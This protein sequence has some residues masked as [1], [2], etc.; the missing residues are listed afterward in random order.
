MNLIKRQATVTTMLFFL[1]T[2]QVNSAEAASTIKSGALCTK[3][4][5]TITSNGN[6][7]K[8]VKSGKKLVWKSL[9]AVMVKPSIAPSPTPAPMSSSTPAP[10]ASPTPTPKPTPTPTPFKANIPITLPLSVSS[11]SNAITF[12]NIVSRVT[13]IPQVAWQK[14][15]N[16]LTA[17]THVSVVTEIFVGP[18]TKLD[19]PGGTKQIEDAVTSTTQLFSGFSQIKHLYVLA[20]NATDEPWAEQKWSNLAVSNGFST[21]YNPEA[22]RIKGNC[23]QSN[24]PGSFSGE[25]TRCGGSNMSTIVDT[26]DGIME[27]GM[28]GD[29]QDPYFLSG[30]LVGHEFTHSIQAAQWIGDLTCGGTGGVHCMK[31]DRAHQIMPCWINEGQ[32]NI[33]GRLS[34][35]STLSEY[36]R[37]REG[38]PYG[39]GPTTITD[40]TESSLHDFLLNDAA[41]NCYES[42]E[43]YKLGYSIGALATEALVA[44]GGPQATM[45]LYAMAAS[46]NDFASAFKNVYGI[47]WKDAVNTL[48]KV[49]YLEYIKFGPAPK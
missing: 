46:G 49:L 43:K 33:I 29:S 7:F 6:N 30:A 21:Q 48:A 31:E 28:T 12:E 13:D 24:A 34:V 19:F 16:A 42:G 8:C 32:P 25:I 18:N 4:N 14:S 44:I 47:E 5:S 27:L 23:Q 20:Y 37:T 38:L 1:I 15:R 11:D 40:Y 35:T 26:N 2:S 39:W 9:G 41:P 3:P 22:I 45:A 10:V 17:S 36:L